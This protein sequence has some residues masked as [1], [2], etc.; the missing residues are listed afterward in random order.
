[1]TIIAGF[2]H[3][4]GI[5][6]TEVPLPEGW[7]MSYSNRILI[8]YIV[9]AFLLTV[10]VLG[11]FSDL[12]L[13]EESSGYNSIKT[14]PQVVRGSIFDRNGKLLANQIKRHSLDVWLPS[15]RDFRL[16]SRIIAPILK[17]DAEQLYQR[18]M[19]SQ[20]NYMW[21]KRFLSERE[22]EEL[23]KHIARGEL[24]GFKLSE[25]YKRY[26]PLG[27]LASHLIGFT[28][29]DNVGLD[30]VER[31][32]ESWLNPKDSE[33]PDGISSS[34]NSRHNVLYGNKVYLSIDIDTQYI[35]DKIAR[36][37][38]IATK[39]DY[40]VS[41]LMDARTGALVAFVSL[42]EYDPNLFNRYPN[43]VLRNQAISTAY[44]PGSVFKIYT[45][46]A[47]LDEKAL[48][49][50]HI[51]DINTVYD[52]PAFQR[53]NIQPIRD[54][55]LH[56]ALS[57]TEVLIY[58]S[59][60]GMA[61]ASENISREALYNKLRLF[62]FSKTTGIQLPGESN[63]ILKRSSQWSIRS[64]PTI[65]FG[66]EI[67]VSAIQM[68][69]AA[70]VF[71]NGG[72]LLA[73]IIIDRIEEPNGDIRLQ[74]SRQPEYEVI[75]PITAKNMLLMMEQVVA[76]DLGTMR[77]S[78][79]EG[80]RISGK[81]GTAQVINP[82]TRQYYPERVNS[83]AI[84][85][86]P[87]DDPHFILYINIF[88]PKS[89]VRYGG[90]LV[91]PMVTEAIS[92]LTTHYNLPLKGNRIA[93]FNE[94]VQTLI[95]KE[96]QKT[97][98]QSLSRSLQQLPDLRG[99]PKRKLLPLLHIPGLIVQIIGEGHVMRQNLPPGTELPQVQVRTR[100]QNQDQ[101]GSGSGPVGSGQTSPPDSEPEPL[102]LKVWLQ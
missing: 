71:T 50:N 72:M 27:E 4:P 48:N 86:F 77:G 1:M 79:V 88:N 6:H 2:G 40:L 16:S 101:D 39:A 11:K 46:A 60:V 69:R 31:S 56:G 17:M 78:R 12:M 75:S 34:G 57:A 10:M 24:S 89:K 65:A 54:V 19:N 37:T 76:S 85:I 53:N 87:T 3:I 33:I 32:L 25:E 43:E 23:G 29:I 26:Y 92:E 38:M 73:P 99:L 18:L 67:G 45:M 66:Q 63:G 93:Y 95:D 70:T 36:K 7:R 61:T 15:V 51:F 28:N 35:I 82:K 96:L 59:N 42:P 94:D 100:T 58:S 5:F 13:R 81:S 20:R 64:K 98:K 44:E 68:V 52:P 74:S 21:I 83:S 90:R 84:A 91:S 41:M 47:M 55:T 14:K 9:V 49:V 62:G 8:F 30:G 102:L 80:L 22:A 97:H